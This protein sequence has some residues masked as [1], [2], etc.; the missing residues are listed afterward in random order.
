[1]EGT[2]GRS[3]IDDLTA[4]SQLRYPKREH[5]VKM[6]PSYVYSDV[7]VKRVTRKC[8]PDAKGKANT[9]H[10]IAPSPSVMSPLAPSHGDPR[11]ILSP[12]L[13]E[14]HDALSPS[15]NG[16]IMLIDDSEDRSNANIGSQ[17]LD[18]RSPDLFTQSYCDSQK[19]FFSTPR[20]RL[21]HGK[22]IMSSDVI[23]S[24]RR[25]LTASLK[26]P[27]SPEFVPPSVSQAMRDLPQTNPADT[28]R[29]LQSELLISKKDLVKEKDENKDLK[30]QLTWLRA[31]LDSISDSHDKHQDNLLLAQRQI[32]EQAKS[33]GELEA[34]VKK[35]SSENE[36]LS[37][38][39]EKLSSENE[40]LSFEK[41]KL[42]SENESLLCQT[43]TGIN[44][45]ESDPTRYFR[46]YWNPL[47]AFYGCRLQPLSG[48][49]KGLT[50]NSLEHLYHYVKLIYHD[51][52]S[53]AKLVKD[54][55]KPADA[56][57][58]AGKLLPQEK[59][60]QSW[61]D[62]RLTTMTDLCSLKAQQCKEFHDA[63]LETG[64][65]HLVH[66]M[67]TDEEW[68]FGHDGK[69]ANLMGKALEATRASLA[70]LRA[71]GCETSPTAVSNTPKEPNG[72]R[73]RNTGETSTKQ[74]LV[75]SDSMLKDVATFMHPMF[76]VEVAA[77]GGYTPKLLVNEI[78][79]VMEGKDFS[80]IVVHCGT[81]CATEK[82]PHTKESFLKVL[83]K[84]RWHTEA[85]ILLSGV[86]HRLDD[87]ALNSR[88][89]AINSIL[90]SLENDQFKNVFFVEHNATIR[91]LGNILKN[92]GLHLR[93][94]GLK[95][96]AENLSIV[97]KTNSKV[98]V[99][100]RKWTAQRG[101]PKLVGPPKTGNPQ[102]KSPQR[103]NSRKKP[104]TTRQQQERILPQSRHKSEKLS[105]H[106]D[107]HKGQGGR[108]DHKPKHPT[109]TSSPRNLH[110]PPSGYDFGV[111]HYCSGSDNRHRFPSPP[112]PTMPSSTPMSPLTSNPP[113]CRASP[114]WAASGHP[115]DWH[116][117]G[118]Y[119]PYPT[120]PSFPH[121]PMPMMRSMP[122]SSW[123]PMY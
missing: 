93:P 6:S 51:L 122:V 15:Q 44:T 45:P 76:D 78:D 99:P 38:E 36:K 35:L 116:S 72:V 66:N 94:S 12:K 77:F 105:D 87:P 92:G 5:K 7:T 86:I 11:P 102:N 52:P 58:L 25:S 39:N 85:P 112:M 65:C 62:S 70:N 107:K 96:I 33:I 103:G 89:D 111:D 2:S 8:A 20:K 69:G 4:K 83:D 120:Y 24:L 98:N 18:N 59:L 46:G 50:F 10:E 118:H 9:T 31:E 68:G 110:P 55:S 49:G 28:I 37:S 119:P 3:A 53:Q 43:A 56:K 71:S 97:L 88:V 54:A 47:S 27:H 109:R 81:N 73:E 123:G 74:V 75:L 79:K 104:A 1:M 91:H 67:E 106:S 63:L 48:P 80:A 13:N 121:W 23:T 117:G 40:K 21:H 14:F 114:Y 108:K 34:Q 60:L 64:K 82:R 22:R 113:N 100:L 29:D 41:E 32:K 57:K 17:W 90:C 115:M 101:Q 19:A 30:Q 84:I 95:Q 61:L 16:S 42:S 26:D